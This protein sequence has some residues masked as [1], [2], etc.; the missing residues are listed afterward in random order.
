MLEFS[1]RQLDEVFRALANPSRRAMV[2]RLTAGPATLSELAA[3]LDMTL[4]AVE[5]HVKVLQGCALVRSAKRGR[6][7]TC[8]LDP[9]TLRGT[10]QWLASNREIWERRLERLGAFLDDE[11]ETPDTRADRTEP[12]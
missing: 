7:R 11:P 12:T 1:E 3:P 2:R 5:Q 8:R 6:V 4:S 10:E 9:D